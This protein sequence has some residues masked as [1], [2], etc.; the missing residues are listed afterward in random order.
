M[1]GPITRHDPRYT[2]CSTSHM[3]IPITHNATI[4]QYPPL[5]TATVTLAFFQRMGVQS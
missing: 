3:L 2:Y 1:L 4:A 5:C